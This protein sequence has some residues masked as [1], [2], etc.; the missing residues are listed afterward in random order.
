MTDC[1][2]CDH[3]P[4]MD[5]ECGGRLALYI[6]DG[7]LSLRCTKCGVEY[8]LMGLCDLS[9]CGRIGQ[10][11]VNLGVE[12]VREAAYGDGYATAEA[13]MADDEEGDAE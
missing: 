8:E 7:S 3:E 4:Y 9:H 10:A 2:R 11:L 5:H 6:E 1:L 13:I 12:M